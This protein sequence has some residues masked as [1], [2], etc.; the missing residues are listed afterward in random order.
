MYSEIPSHAELSGYNAQHNDDVDI[1]SENFDIFILIIIDM[2]ISIPI[3]DK[4]ELCYQNIP[5]ISIS[6]KNAWG[7]PKISI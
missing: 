1:I 5:I 6:M 3:F 4:S 2:K 7:F